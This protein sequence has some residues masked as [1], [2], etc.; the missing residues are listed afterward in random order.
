MGSYPI[1]LAEVNHHF[2]YYNP[3]SFGTRFYYNGSTPLKAEENGQNLKP[4]SQPLPDQPPHGTSVQPRPEPPVAPATVS[5]DG[6]S[7]LVGE[8]KE[9][10]QP[11]FDVE[12]SPTPMQES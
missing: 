1:L 7:K 12:D 4:Y 8:P 9:S 5:G 6:E 3:E 2:L 10:G 11:V